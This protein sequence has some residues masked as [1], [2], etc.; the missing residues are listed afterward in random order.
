MT[1]QV[2]HIKIGEKPQ[3]VAFK[4]VNPT[5]KSFYYTLACGINVR[6]LSNET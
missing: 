4:Y 6:L 3:D 1:L 5:Y 2:H